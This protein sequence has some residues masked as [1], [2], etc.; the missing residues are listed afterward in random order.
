MKTSFSTPPASR[1]LG[2]RETDLRI[3]RLEK[4]SWDLKHRIMLYQEQAKRTNEELDRREKEI[5][6]LQSADSRNNQLEEEIASLQNQ[7]ESTQEENN[8]LQETNVELLSINEDV[9][10]QLE[11]RDTELR[12]LAK[13]NRGR[14]TAIE[15]AAGIIQTLEQRLIEADLQMARPRN[16]T[17]PQPD[18]D[19]FSGDSKPMPALTKPSPSL[20]NPPHLG[21]DSDYFSADT[22]PLITPRSVKHMPIT[23]KHLPTQLFATK[24]ISVVFNREMGIRST[25]SKDSLLSKYLETPELPQM[26]EIVESSPKAPSGVNRLRLLRKRAEIGKTPLRSAEAPK[27]KKS[28]HQG[29]SENRP[30]RNLYMNGELGLQ[31]QTGPRAL[32][33]L[34]STDLLGRPT[35]YSSSPDDGGQKARSNPSISVAISNEHDQHN[36]PVGPS[37]HVRSNSTSTRPPGP[38]LRQNTTPARSSP[39]RSSPRTTRVHPASVTPI[40]FVAPVSNSSQRSPRLS[41]SQATPPHTRHLRAML[42]ETSSSPAPLVSIVPAT[43]ATPQAQTAPTYS[44]TKQTT[45]THKAAVPNFSFWP[46]RYPAWP[47]S[48]GLTNRNLLYHGNDDGDHSPTRTDDGSPTEERERHW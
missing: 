9:V 23:G 36:T 28:P 25:A 13:D 24:E 18:S 21:P 35:P 15:E 7:L 46:K 29:W 1:P 30:L 8:R 27:A 42:Q 37:H 2:S 34:P 39:T 12:N 11:Q 19:Y 6:R 20:S 48:A 5:E 4:E 22:S 16:I 33:A 14:Q 38:L 47:P 43:Y 17:T 3:D 40:P 41:Q 45:Q 31:I 44:I 32:P 26:P 10:Q